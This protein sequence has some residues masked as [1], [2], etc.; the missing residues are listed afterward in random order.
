DI[1]YDGRN[2]M[3]IE[4]N[5]V[6]FFINKDD[7]I[8]P[9][10]KLNGDFT[11]IQI[12]DNKLISFQLIKSPCCTNYV[13][14]IEDYEFNNLEDCYRPNNQNHNYYKYSYGQ[15]NESSFCVSLVSQYAYV[16]KTEFPTKI[17][18]KGCLTVTTKTYLTPKPLEPSNVDFKEDGLAFHFMKNK[19]ISELPIGTVCQVLTEKK[20]EKGNIYCFVVLK[21]NETGK[22][23]MNGIEFEQYGWVKKDDLK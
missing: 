22:N 14:K 5:N 15:L 2:P 12:K 4:T 20:D 6:V 3:G 8:R 16:M 19:A 10:I 18:N 7:S 9:V 1:I 13:F 17:D 21:N 11:K 23:Y